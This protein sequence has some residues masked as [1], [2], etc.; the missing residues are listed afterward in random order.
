MARKRAA[1]MHVLA[2]RGVPARDRLLRH[3]QGHRVGGRADPGGRDHRR[4]LP[5]RHGPRSRGRTAR[6][7]SWTAATEVIVATNAFGMGVDKAD[8]HTVVH[9][10]LP[11]SLEAYYQEAGRAGRDGQPARAVLLAA[12]VDLG[13]LI[14]FIKERETSVEDVKRFVGSLRAGSDDGQRR[15]GA[16]GARRTLAG[17]AVDRRARRGRRA[18]PGDARGT[19]RDAHRAGKH[20]ARPSVAIQAARNRVWEAYHSIER[21]SSGSGRLPPPAD[22]RALRRSRG[23]LSAGALL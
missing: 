14:R 19:A 7:R 20:R 3:P 13:R 11:T 22:P 12:R 8:V 4:R 23:R 9:W 16:R 10:A 18:G 21:Y 2:G 15:A 6:R 1:L 5:R 17:A